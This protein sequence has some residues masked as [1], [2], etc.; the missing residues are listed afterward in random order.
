MQHGFCENMVLVKYMVFG[1]EKTWFMVK[2]WFLVKT[3]LDD[4]S[5]SGLETNHVIS[6]PKRGL[7]INI[8]GRGQT[9][10]HVNTHTDNATL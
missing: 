5:M 8:T 9:Y 1:G 2:T 7:K 4:G 6:G 10:K 3:L